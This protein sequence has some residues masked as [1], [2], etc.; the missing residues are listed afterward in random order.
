MCRRPALAAFLQS[1]RH[2]GAIMSEMNK[3]AHP[4]C[5]CIVSNDG[6]FGKYC[7]E[8]CQEAKDMAEIRCECGHAGCNHAAAP[9]A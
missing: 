8:H 1:L 2:R 3:C 7:S 5:K 4:A 9:L 6:Q